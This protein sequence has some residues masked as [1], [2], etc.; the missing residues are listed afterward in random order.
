MFGTVFFL[1]PMALLIMYAV[2]AVF[3]RA[4]NSDEVSTNAG[5]LILWPARLLVPIGFFLLVAA[6]RLAS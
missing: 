2:V 4:W 3:V 6:G 5:G 1:L